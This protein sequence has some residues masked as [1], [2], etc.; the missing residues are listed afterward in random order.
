MLPLDEHFNQVLF[1]QT[2]QVYARGRRTHVR[3]HRKL[4]AC[5]CM[6]IHQA[7]KHAHARRLTDGSRN[8]G[9]RSVSVVL[10]IH[11]FIIDEVLMSNN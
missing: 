1:L 8:F 3:H 5:S 9:D 11:T 7:V 2:I 4:G 10:D 6:A